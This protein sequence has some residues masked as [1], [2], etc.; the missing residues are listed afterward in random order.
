MRLLHS[1]KM[2]TKMVPLN[3]MMMIA[4]KHFAYGLLRHCVCVC[5]CA[6]RCSLGKTRLSLKASFFF[7]SSFFFVCSSN[8][9]RTND[10]IRGQPLLRPAKG[11]VRATWVLSDPCTPH[12][13][14]A[15][16]LRNVTYSFSLGKIDEQRESAFP[17]FVFHTRFAWRRGH[18]LNK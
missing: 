16:P 12:Y 2:K 10:V 4:G 9:N 15:K 7:L 3:G 5:V 13:P 1:W 6:Q 8:L 11:I 14:S 18:D 17:R